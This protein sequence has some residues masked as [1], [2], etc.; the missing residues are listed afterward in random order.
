MMYIL[1]LS[2]TLY[3]GNSSRLYAVSHGQF[4]PCFQ[5]FSAFGQQEVGESDPWPGYI[6]INPFNSTDLA[7]RF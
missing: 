7:E 3:T 2:R 1:V 4:L 5:L 6:G